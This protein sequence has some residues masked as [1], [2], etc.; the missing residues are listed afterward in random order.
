M[1]R[2]D[3]RVIVLTGKPYERRRV[4]QQCINIGP[5]TPA[6]ICF[7]V[8]C[9]GSSACSVLHPKM[10][11]RRDDE[12]VRTKSS[13]THTLSLSLSHAR[14]CTHIHMLAGTHFQQS[15]SAKSILRCKTI[16]VVRSWQRMSLKHIRSST[17]RVQ[18]QLVGSM[19]VCF[20]VPM[21]TQ[22][23]INGRARN[24]IIYMCE[25]F[26]RRVRFGFFFS[27]VYSCYLDRIQFVHALHRL[28]FDSL[29]IWKLLCRAILQINFHHMSLDHCALYA[30]GL[31][32][33]LVFYE[34]SNLCQKSRF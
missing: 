10:V 31:Y 25:T 17:T 8:S 3:D 19:T 22:H 20:V 4:Y 13:N 7:V 2:G 5:D 33:P 6:T 28:S 11:E 34:R 12:L 29:Q 15:K 32:G 14:A 16:S 27:V 21:S 18:L 9:P 26:I 23:I 30:V 1:S 24:D